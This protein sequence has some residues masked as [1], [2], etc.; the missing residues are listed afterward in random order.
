MCDLFPNC[1]ELESSKQIDSICLSVRTTI[2]CVGKSL[3]K[4]CL[5]IVRIS[6]DCMFTNIATYLKLTERLKDL[7]GHKTSIRIYHVIDKCITNSF[8]WTRTSLAILNC[9]CAQF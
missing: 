9:S 6:Y 7:W 4:G 2:I 3:Y 5:V 1:P 8:F